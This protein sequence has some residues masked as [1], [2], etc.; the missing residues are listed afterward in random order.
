[1]S[2]RLQ[3]GAKVKATGERLTGPETTLP[4]RPCPD[5]GAGLCEGRS[6]RVHVFG[7]LPRLDG[8]AGEGP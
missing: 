8:G 4:R 3:R 7:D 5:A 2:V 6:L 1:M